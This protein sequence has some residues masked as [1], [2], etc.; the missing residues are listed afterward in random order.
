MCKFNIRDKKKGGQNSTRLTKIQLDASKMNMPHCTVYAQCMHSVCTVYAQCMH[1]VC[2]VYAQCMHSVCTVYAQCMHSVC[3]VYAQC[4]HS[5]CTVYA[6]CMHSVCTVYAQC[7]HS[8]CTVYAQCMHSVCTVYTRLI[9]EQTT[10][11]HSKHIPCGAWEARTRTAP[12]SVHSGASG[13]A[14]TGTSPSAPR[15][16]LSLCDVCV[17]V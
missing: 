16:A 13:F 11:K 5:V 12:A 17:C 9:A 7:M 6:Q 2:T 10:Q 1:S 8:V 15:G 14:Q 3:T 4:M